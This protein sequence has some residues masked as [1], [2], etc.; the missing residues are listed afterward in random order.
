MMR[1]TLFTIFLAACLLAL[2]SPLRA[3]LS[4]DYRLAN[5]LMQQEKYEQAYRILSDLLKEHPGVYALYD[6][7]LDCLV[8]L[9]RYDEAIAL[10]EQQ[11]RQGYNPMQTSVR[12]GEIY[13]LSGDTTKAFQL[14]DR[15]LNQYSDNLQTYLMLGQTMQQRRA[16]DRA[17]K[18]YEQARSRFNSELFVN[19]LAT[20]YLQAGQYDKAIGTLLS[21]VASHPQRLS[22]VQRILSRFNDDELYDTAILEVDDFLQNHAYTEAGYDELQQLQIW[23]L[24]E[25]QLY[26]RAVASARSYESRTPR[27]TYLLFNLGNRLQSLQ[28]YELAAEAFNY[29]SSRP[30]SPLHNRATEALGHTYAQWADYLHDYNLSYADRQNEL[31]G[32]AFTTLK[33][34]IDAS[35]AYEHADRVLTTLTELSLDH[36]H[37]I[38]QARNYYRTLID[39][40]EA[41]PA[42]REYLDGRIK[43]YEKDYARA[44][45]AF[46]RSNK[47]A[48]LGELAE[49]SRYY[50][51][52]TDFYAGDFEYATL[53]L[54]ALERQNTS[55]FANDAV[56]LRVWIQE[57]IEADST[58][59]LLRPFADAVEAFNRGAVDTAL[60][61]L[62]PVFEGLRHPLRDDALLLL[63]EQSEHLG[64]P[65]LYAALS[66]YLAQGIHSPLRERL[67][68]EKARIADRWRAQPGQ[69][70]TTANASN[71][72]RALSLEKTPVPTANEEVLKL[73]QQVILE[74]PTGFYAAFARNRIRE[75]Q[76]QQT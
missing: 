71:R 3:Q 51:S 22:F 27:T 70:D 8:N 44:R 14:W 74:Y 12:L 57:G 66:Q 29:Y 25:K 23:L 17:V 49:K 37:D 13:H 6:R 55:Y 40:D 24:L 43:L 67:L 56:K 61:D 53:Q 38:A 33:D 1:R 7:A 60:A 11:L 28:E 42:E 45:I 31:Y 76:K 32:K 34:L 35:P 36:L 58:G 18:V 21:L 46:T 19:D 75:L 72:Y 59:G 2:A 47:Q 69:S 16:Y 30:E 54:K 39:H 64:L 52:L 41:R 5:Q 62:H 68:W 63:S 50:L 48:R 15:T 9:K 73:Y 10:S 65:L 26:P 20:A 4:N